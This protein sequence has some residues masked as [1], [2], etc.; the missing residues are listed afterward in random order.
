MTM[1][2]VIHGDSLDV[3]RQ[4]DDN[5]IDAIVTDPPYGLAFMGKRWDY[6]V[7]SVELW[8]ECLRVLKPGGHLLAFAG[9]RTQHRMA[10]RIEDA[11]FEIRDMIMWVYSTGFPK[12]HNGPWGG[13][14]LKPA[15]E[16]ITVAR[17]PLQG[18]LAA[19]VLQWGT[20]GLN[21]DACRVGTEE[22]TRS[23]SGD[24]PSGKTGIYGKRE[25]IEQSGVGRWPA[26]LVHDGSEEIADGL[27]H[28]ARFYYVAKASRRERDAG[29]EGM[30]MQQLRT[31]YDKKVRD[32]HGN[33]SGHARSNTHATVKPIALM[34]WLIKLVTPP[35]GVVLDPFAGSGTTGCA[36]AR[37][38]VRSILIER[39][40]EYVEIARRR[41]SYWS[42]ELDAAAD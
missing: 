37:L 32:N 7:P 27:G 30:P 35:G 39:E 6:D 15:L 4:M 12:S 26:N 19:N 14:A 38:G 9:T 22:W 21:I 5:S 31:T 3:L 2:Q 28:A 20:G 41:V 34:E 36:A 13:S 23:A 24:V 33:D 17:K 25:R 10:V 16:P 40:A 11:G 42:A 29:L 1:H 8:A 18:T